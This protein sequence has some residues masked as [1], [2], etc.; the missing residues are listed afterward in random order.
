MQLEQVTPTRYKM[1]LHTYELA[2]LISAARWIAEGAKGELPP[3]AIKQMQ[4]I[5]EN[6]DTA[7]QRLQDVDA[8]QV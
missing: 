7:S 5:V 8:G 2:T 4:D 3:E 1:T 6:Y